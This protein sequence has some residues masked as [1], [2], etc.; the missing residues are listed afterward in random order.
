MKVTEPQR[1]A[2]QADVTLGF[3]DKKILEARI[4]PCP[5]FDTMRLF[6]KNESG[7]QVQDECQSE[8]PNGQAG[9]PRLNIYSGGR[10]DSHSNV[11]C[12]SWLLRPEAARASGLI[13]F[14]ACTLARRGERC[15]E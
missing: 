8:L 4:A 6:T 7:S 10:L 13:Q 3:M 15:V 14:S 9:C 2:R 12:L 11:P 1:M 5:V